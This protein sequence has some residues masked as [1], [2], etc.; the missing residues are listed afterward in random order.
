MSRHLVHCIATIALACITGSAAAHT[1]SGDD[2]VN[3][4]QGA[5]RIM[6][7][8]MGLLGDVARGEKPFD[9]AAVKRWTRHLQWAERLTAQ[10]YTPD[11]RKAAESRMKSEAW[12]SFADFKSKGKDLKMAIDML[13]QKAADKD[14]NAIRSAIGKVGEACKSCH[15]RYRQDIPH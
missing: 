15:D 13:A 3:F 9:A 8:H 12:D 5:Y 6:G 10:T 2:R 11:T 1:Q 4:R 14:T 7:W